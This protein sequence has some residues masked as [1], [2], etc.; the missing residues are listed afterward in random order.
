MRYVY[1]QGY[2][3]T[4]VKYVVLGGSYFVGVHI[5]AARRSDRYTALT[6]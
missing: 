6:L 5:D 4:T 3:L 1:R 2:G